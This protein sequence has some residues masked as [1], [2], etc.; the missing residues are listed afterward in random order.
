MDSI[1]KRLREFQKIQEL[2]Q[3][4]HWMN[5]L[6]PLG[7]LLISVMYIFTVV[8]FDK[9]ALAPL[10]LMAVYPA[11]G[12]IVGELSLRMGIYRMRLILPLVLFVG[13]L[14]PFFDRDILFYVGEIGI[15][16]GVISMITLMLKGFYA[17]LAAYILIATTSIE[18][19]CYA[20]R[21]IH[22]PKII[23]IVIL[24]IERYF[25]IMGEEA[26]RI[27]T[28]YKL[29]APRQKGIH[30]SAWGTLVGMWLIRSMDRAGVVYESMLLRGFKGDFDMEEIKARPFDIIYTI[31]WIAIFVFI[32]NI[33]KI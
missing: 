24:L 4:S 20:L 19:L 3:R 1:E 26:D 17:V 21:L 10:I 28:A 7:K 6:H 18:K 2:W 13:I 9:Y 25:F 27:A 15:S 31:A 32:R 30:Y 8:S 12:F 5:D 16:G 29:R 11:F 23:V 33:I 14:N 22:V